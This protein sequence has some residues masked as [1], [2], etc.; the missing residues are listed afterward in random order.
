M[1]STAFA[2]LPQGSPP[3]DT[4]A[5]ATFA[6]GCF[7]CMESPFAHLNGVIK[8]LPG[9]TGGKTVNPTYEQVCSGKTGHLEAVQVTYDPRKITY[10]EL[11]DVFWRNINPTDAGGQF[12]DRGI[13][14]HTAIFYHTPEQKAEATASRDALEK[15]GK[16][17][18][19]IVTAIRPAVVFYP[20]E[21]YHR[22]YYLKNAEHY[23]QYREGSGRGP[24]LRRLWEHDDTT[25]HSS[26]TSSLS[27]IKFTYQRPGDDQLKKSLTKMQYNVAVCSATEPPF[28]NAYWNNHRDGIYV[29][30][31]TGE[32]LFSSKDKFNSGT[33]WP[34]FTRPIDS[35]SVVEKKD[36]SHGMQR[37]E[38]RS[39]NGDAHLG[40]LFP[41]GP[42]P[43]GMRY[44]IN[45]AS[46]KF[47]PKEDLEKEGYGKYLSIFR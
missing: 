47:V 25:L 45:S 35:I 46:L 42:A 13:Q 40:H 44:C 8:V 24:Y 28:D 3:A 37:I 41:D 27:K 26:T 22:E 2:T 32:P 18:D 33:G 23:K 20:A 31:L 10:R 43:T 21:D 12:A 36:T 39:K 11:L 19:V 4:S 17:E 14:Y 1:L 34:S 6:G 9:Y 7:W 38:V 5:A 29:D 16:F 15:S 30:I